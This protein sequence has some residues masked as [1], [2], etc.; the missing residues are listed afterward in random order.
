MSP[1]D[2]WQPVPLGWRDA[3]AVSA[4]AVRIKKRDPRLLLLDLWDWAHCFGWEHPVAFALEAIEKG[5]GW[6]GRRGILYAALVETGWVR[7]SDGVA[8][9]CRWKDEGIVIGRPTTRKGAAKKATI[10][11]DEKRERDRVRKQKSRDSK[12]DIAMSQ[13]VTW[14]DACDIRDGHTVTP[15]T[16]I[17]KTLVLQQSVTPQEQEQEQEKDQIKSLALFAPAPSAPVV[18]RPK[19][20]PKAKPDSGPNAN[21][22]RAR[23]LEQARRLLNLT[24]EEAPESDKFCIR[25]AQTRKARGMEQMMKALEGLQ[26][27]AFAKTTDLMYLV[28]DSAITR[29][30]AKWKKEAGTIHI[31]RQYGEIDPELGF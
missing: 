11:P 19:R 1:T 7:E 23:W 14:R 25:F 28:S 29:G 24:A 5:A 18:A 6:H 4:L 17:Q 30:I 21:E 20:T 2:Y 13:P 26:N 12:R 3:P 16:P 9:I 10:D 15:V 31:S 22:D 27:D 8:V